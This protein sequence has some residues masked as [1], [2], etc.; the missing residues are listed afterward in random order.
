[1]SRRRW[2]LT[3]AEQAEFRKRIERLTAAGAD[4]DRSSFE[5][6]SRDWIQVTHDRISIVHAL[7]TSSL[8]VIPAR[9]VALAPKIIIRGFELS[10]PAL[11]LATWFL[12]DPTVSRSDDTRYRFRDGTDFDRSEVL[13]HRVEASGTLRH[14]DLMEGLLLA[15]SFDV[16]PAGFADKSPIP[17]SLSIIN[18]FGDVHTS[19]TTARLMRIAER[20]QPRPLRRRS[21]FDPQDGPSCNSDWVVEVPAAEEPVLLNQVEIAMPGML[22]GPLGHENGAMRKEGSSRSTPAEMTAQT[23]EPKLR[24]SALFIG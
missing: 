2:T 11:D 6:A 13:N 18:Q 23:A 1:M 3:Q 5:S 9:I 21:L 24:G 20:I 14:G 7:P 12:E 16:I 10:S 19:T 22:S 15:D 4:L 17:I 8:F